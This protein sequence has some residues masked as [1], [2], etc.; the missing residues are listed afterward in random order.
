VPTNTE[1]REAVVPDAAARRLST[2]VARA[3]RGTYGAR[4]GLRTLVRSVSIQMLRSGSSPEAVSRALEDFILSR[5]APAAVGSSIGI[6]D[7]VRAH[8]RIALAADIADEMAEQRPTNG[9]S[10][11]G[12][13]SPNSPG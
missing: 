7:A 2:Q 6:N 4:A 9:A 12:N 11:R 13:A 10:T 3:Y 1:V 8:V 5:A